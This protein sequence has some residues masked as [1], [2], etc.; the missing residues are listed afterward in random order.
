MET[1]GHTDDEI[2][3]ILG[4]RKIAVVGMSRDP[5]KGPTM[6]QST[7]RITAMISPPSTPRRTAYWIE[8]AIPT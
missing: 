8:G 4:Y 7:L 6:S 5:S 1:D 3:R 2:R